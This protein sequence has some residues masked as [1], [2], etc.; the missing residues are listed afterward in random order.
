MIH[1]A[2]LIFVG[3]VNMRPN[4]DNFPKKSRNLKNGYFRR[5]QMK[6]FFGHFKN[7]CLVIFQKTKKNGDMADLSYL[8]G[9][10]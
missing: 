2:K 9:A 4:V 6:P 7:S 8:G 1:H 3:V 5:S 10:T